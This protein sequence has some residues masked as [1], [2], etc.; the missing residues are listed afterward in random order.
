MTSSTGAVLENNGR[1]LTVVGVEPKIL[2]KERTLVSNWNATPFKAALDRLKIAAEHRNSHQR[3]FEGGI[4][5]QLRK[6][7]ST[8]STNY[9]SDFLDLNQVRLRFL[10]DK[11]L[12][13]SA[14]HSDR[15][16]LLKPKVE[17][18]QSTSGGVQTISPT[19]ALTISYSIGCS[20]GAMCQSLNKAVAT[21]LS[22]Y[23]NPPAG[24]GAPG[25]YNTSTGFTSRHPT[26]CST[27]WSLASGT[28]TTSAKQP[29]SRTPAS[30]VGSRGLD[31]GNGGGGVESGKYRRTCS[32]ELINVITIDDGVIVTKSSN[33]GQCL[34][35]S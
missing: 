15:G 22:D 10:K 35:D 19:E 18:V 20:S 23:G 1:N 27:A 12:K 2:V 8:A 31:G 25:D 14:P 21:G 9:S 11:D 7:R 16:R 5:G 13:D 29:Y 26:R 28:G 24:Y 33:E 34:M 30:G 3:S 6:S 17:S 32:N 4:H